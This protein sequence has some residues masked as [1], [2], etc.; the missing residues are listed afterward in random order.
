[1]FVLR[2]TN[3]LCI[4]YRDTRTER[5]SKAWIVMRDLESWRKKIHE[6]TAPKI[7]EETVKKVAEGLEPE[8]REILWTIWQNRHANIDELAELIAAPNHMDVLLK[9]KNIINPRSEK[10]TGRPILT[11]ERSKI[12][13]GTGE[14]ILFSWWIMGEREEPRIRKREMP[15]DVFDEG[16]HVNI[17]MDLMG[18]QEKDVSLKVERNKLTVLSRTAGKTFQ[19]EIYLPAEVHPDKTAKNFNNNILRVI[20]HKR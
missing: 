8:S 18:L 19:E 6:L 1:M 4:C 10:I 14:K 20:L 3:V 12:D 13:D 15:I 16:D 17:I 11:F 2:T 5:A 9:I 7:E